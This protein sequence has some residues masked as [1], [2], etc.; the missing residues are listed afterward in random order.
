[1]DCAI[2]QAEMEKWDRERWGEAGKDT[3]LGG[4]PWAEAGGRELLQRSVGRGFQAEGA[5]SAKGE[6]GMS[7]GWFRDVAEWR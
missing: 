1:M 6:A 4:E 2:I 7:W 3:P 5:V